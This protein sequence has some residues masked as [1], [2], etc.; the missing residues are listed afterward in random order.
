[1]RMAIEHLLTMTPG[2]AC[3]DNDDDSPGNEWRMR[4]Q[5][6]PDWLRY[7]LELR[8]SHEPGEFAA[9][10]SAGPNLAGGVLSKTAG[11]WLPDLF[12]RCFALPLQ[13]DSHLALRR[14]W[15]GK[16]EVSGVAPVE[17]I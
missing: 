6:N 1:M 4:S 13:T 7:T 12:Q 10:C 3:D 14:R 9:H 15:R 17:A 8:M 2:L 11:A 5:A 16:A